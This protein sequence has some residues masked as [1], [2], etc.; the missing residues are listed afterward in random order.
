MVLRQLSSLS[1]SVQPQCCLP[2]N[3]TYYRSHG[4][5]TEIKGWNPWES[6][7]FAPLHLVRKLSD[8]AYNRWFDGYR[9]GMSITFW[10]WRC[11]LLWIGIRPCFVSD[12]NNAFSTLWSW[13]SLF[14]NNLWTWP[15]S[16][17]ADEQICIL[18]LGRDR[19][20][21]MR[22]CAFDCLAFRGAFG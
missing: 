3:D 13:N 14:S 11:D 4:T 7:T 8:S 16:F 20:V 2:K 22:L 6:L 15:G 19:C 18:R 9:V 1:Q 21:S 5:R 12:A 10:S 17:Q